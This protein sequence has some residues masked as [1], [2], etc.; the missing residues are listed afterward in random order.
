MCRPSCR[1][2]S[3]LSA[4]AEADSCSRSTVRLLEHA[5][6]DALDHVPLAANLDRDRVDAGL[7]QEMAEQQARRSGADD[8]DGGS[9]VTHRM[10][11]QSDAFDQQ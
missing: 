7:L 3:R 6:A 9:R 5:G 1:I 4:L 8:P 11:G 10:K 2:P